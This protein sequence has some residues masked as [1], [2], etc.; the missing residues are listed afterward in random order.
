MIF[1]IAADWEVQAE[2]TD[3]TSRSMMVLSTP[4]IATIW[5]A[6]VPNKDLLRRAQVE[7][8]AA[9][10]AADGQTR[11]SGTQVYRWVQCTVRQPARGSMQRIRSPTRPAR[12]TCGTPPECERVCAGLLV[13][14]AVRRADRSGTRCRSGASIILAAAALNRSWCITRPV[15][16]RFPVRASI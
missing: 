5:G 3:K 11:L 16:I 10:C 7:I 12:I 13:D 14:A 9:R 15:R 8:S 1:W 4:S 6:P 2:V